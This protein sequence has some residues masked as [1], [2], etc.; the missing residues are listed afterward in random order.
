MSL[1]PQCLADG[2]CQEAFWQLQTLLRT[3][4]V[5]SLRKLFLNIQCERLV[6][7]VFLFCAHKVNPPEV[8][9][10][11]GLDF[12]SLSLNRGGCCGCSSLKW[13]PPESLICL[14]FRGRIYVSTSW[15]W[16]SWLAD[17]LNVAKQLLGHFQVSGF[18]KL[19]PYVLC[20]LRLSF[21]NPA[22]MLRGCPA[23][24]KSPHKRIQPKSSIYC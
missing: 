23:Y 2:K 14:L 9:A 1:F 8:A 6:E 17:Q 18:K 4:D 13:W 19:L 10:R 21:W 3:F 16:V 24:M 22:T 7:F 5:P 20:L 12:L 15:T 11:A